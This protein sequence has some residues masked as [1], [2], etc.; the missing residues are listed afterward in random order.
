MKSFDDVV[1][2]LLCASLLKDAFAEL[3]LGE[4]ELLCTLTKG[5]WLK[6][7][8]TFKCALSQSSFL[9]F[10]KNGFLY[11]QSFFWDLKSLSIIFS[12]WTGIFNKTNI[13]SWNQCIVDKS[14]QNILSANFLIV[15]ILD[16]T[17]IYKTIYSDNK[18]TAICL[19]KLSKMV[20]FKTSILGGFSR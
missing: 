19:K 15:V 20:K 3:C 9:F 11:K 5:K 4:N 7:P 8:F 17:H 6:L 1:L 14:C 2:D 18:P 13:I 16:C 12:P 10:F